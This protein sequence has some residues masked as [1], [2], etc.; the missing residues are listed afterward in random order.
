METKNKERLVKNRYFWIGVFGILFFLSL[1]FWAWNVDELLFGFLPVWVLWLM[2][3]Q[4]LLSIS[5]FFFTKKYWIKEDD[6]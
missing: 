2:T 6:N 4:W 5:I 1:D 3:L